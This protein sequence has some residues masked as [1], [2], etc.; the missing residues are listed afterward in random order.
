M[1]LLGN[2]D[3]SQVQFGLLAVLATL[4][5]VARADRAVVGAAGARARRG[6]PG[7]HR[8]GRA[9][10][11]RRAPA[12]LGAADPRA[13]PAPG[14]RAARGAAAGPGPGAGAA[15]LALRP[16]GRLRHARPES[17]PSAPGS[18][19]RSPRPR[20]RWRTPTRSTVRPVVVG[21]DRPL[22][23]GLRALVLAA[24][25]AMVNA[26]KHAGVERGRASTSR[27]SR[28]R[29]TCSCATAASASIRTPCPPTGTASPTR[30][31]A[32]WSGTAVRSA[33]EHPGRGHRGAAEHAG[34]GRAGRAGARREGG[35]VMTGTPERGCRAPGAG[36]SWSTTTRLF[37][38]GVRAE[39]DRDAPGDRRWWARPAPSPRRSPRSGTCGPTWC[40]S[41]C[42]CPTAAGAEVLRQ[43][44]AAEVGRSRW[45][46]WR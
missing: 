21:G 12:R 46:S 5:G 15:A 17:A 4:V 44:R 29:C 18:P 45:C 34:D 35:D 8:R 32:G 38:A 9:G 42:T 37:R 23:D 33:A 43:V 11:D 25:E 41:T 13:H 10:G 3:L 40:C 28:P 22:D 2:L 26:A 20:P 7:A 1:F 24:R 16:T 30:S 27:S 36:R 14:R 31:A 6:A 19:P 39:L